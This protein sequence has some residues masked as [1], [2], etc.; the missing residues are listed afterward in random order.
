MSHKD[1]KFNP[2]VADKFRELT[3]D[4]FKTRR[5]ELGMTQGDLCRCAGLTQPQLSRFEEGNQNLTINSLAAVAG[6]LRIKITYEEM[7]Y[8]TPAGFEPI[9]EN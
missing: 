6:C 2:Q 7:D 1:R 9:N 3:G 8:N 4:F 5:I